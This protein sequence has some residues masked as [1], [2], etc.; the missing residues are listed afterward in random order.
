[1]NVTCIFEAGPDSVTW[2]G[3]GETLVVQAWGAHSLRVRSSAS[4]HVVDN[5]FALLPQPPQPVGI[6]VDGEVATLVNGE[7]TAILRARE[8]HD[9]QVGHKVL[10]CTLE[11]KDGRGETVL[12]ELDEGGSLKL[13]AR[14]YRPQSGSYRVKASFE[15]I[16]DEKLYGM[17]QYQ[18]AVADLK[19]STLELAHRNSQVSV[20]FVVS[21]AGYGFLWHNP[22][23][24]SATFASNRTE[25][26]A[27]STDQ[28]D[29]WVT[30]GSTP[31]RLSSALADATGHVP[32]MPEY[33]LGYWQCK[34]R[35]WNQEQLLEVAREHHRRGLPLDVIVADFFHWP[36]MGDYRFENEFWPDPA[37]M[38]AELKELGV[39][40]M[41]SI[42]PQVSL[43]SENF[44]RF[45]KENLLV[46]T[47]RGMGIHM[48]FQGPS[49]FLDVTNPRARETVWEICKRNYHDLGVKVF[50]LD[51]A[52]PEYGVYDFDNYRYHAG[53]NVQIGNIYP[54]AYSRMFYEGQRAAGQEDIVN[55]VRCA[56]L[57]SQRFGAL[58]WSGDIHSTWDD[59]RNQIAAGIHIGVAGIPWFTTDIGGFHGG[60]IEDPDFRDLLVRWFQFG[61]FCPVM[62]MHGDRRPLQDVSAADGSLRCPT[63][64]PNELWS[65]GDDVLD[66]LAGYV[67]LR[68]TLRPY[69][70]RV[71]ADAHE[72]GQPVMRGLFHEFPDDPQ[73]WNLVDQYMFGPDLL[74]APVIEA[75]A[76]C[77]ELYLPAGASWTDIHTGQVHSGGQ[78]LTVAAP[79][80]VI[81]VFA[82]EGAGPDVTV[83][84]QRSL[85]AIFLPPAG[86][87]AGGTKL[88][89][90]SEHP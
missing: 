45:K 10:R 28:L 24:G 87:E 83:L 76:T 74:V 6:R 27:E 21:S 53:P 47:E 19:G 52:E 82:R 88:P 63:G 78:W 32:M 7:I 56:W 5:D 31:A 41:V 4:G 66:I 37:A 77:R 29:Y 61:T 62:R 39:E 60:N 40:L 70:R 2:R 81:P 67:R 48:G 23:I 16:R 26:V 86:L 9:D 35:Y 75:H 34:L 57:G 14:E 89:A 33:G 18:Q 36:K 38:V 49:V 85:S 20:P 11:V 58:V 30:V 17:G 69:T 12:K 84:H 71:M 80:D 25:W 65:F 79:V 22:A 64:A 73:S 15:S 13:K 50:W 72:F 68:E 8:F 90:T 3:D 54:Q 44:G 59:L 51:E 43:E 1:M 42:W 46:R 55:L